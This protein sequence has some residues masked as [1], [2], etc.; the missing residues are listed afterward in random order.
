MWSKCLPSQRSHGAPTSQTSTIMQIP[1]NS[2][3]WLQELQAA[4][5]PHHTHPPPATPMRG[6]GLNRKRQTQRH[7]PPRW[8]PSQGTKQEHPEGGNWTFWFFFQ[9]VLLLIQGVSSALTGWA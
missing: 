5:L 7:S 8:S 6:R 2:Q 4:F 1:Q 3:L 9:D